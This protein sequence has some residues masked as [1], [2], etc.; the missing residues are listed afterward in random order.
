[1]IVAMP[2][3][4]VIA[5]GSYILAVVDVFRGAPL[6]GGGALFVWYAAVT[7]LGFGIDWDARLRTI[8]AYAGMIAATAIGV[9]G[10]THH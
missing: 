2:V 4:F 10:F 1:M 5:I 8:A 9:L 7:P 3:F 6:Y